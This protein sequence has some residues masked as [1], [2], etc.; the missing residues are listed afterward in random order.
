V[1]EGQRFD[2]R[3]LRPFRADLSIRKSFLS[4]FDRSNKP[5]RFFRHGLPKFRLTDLDIS[6]G[7]S[8]PSKHF[9]RLPQPLRRQP[10]QL[11]YP[12]SPTAFQ[13]RHDAQKAFGQPASASP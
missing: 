4:A 12:S 6:A 11:P 2:L 7:L 10:R 13:A 8:F 3:F 9:H 1:Y 5:T